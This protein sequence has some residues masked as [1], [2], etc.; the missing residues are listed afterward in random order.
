VKELVQW[1]R[2]NPGKAYASPGTGT[3]PQLTGALFTHSLNLDIVACAVLGRRRR[4]RSHRR[5]PHADLVRR[6]GARRCR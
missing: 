6:H 3:P 1:V 4:S 2:T 5:Q